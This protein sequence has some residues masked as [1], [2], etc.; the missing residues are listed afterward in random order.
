[1]FAIQAILFI[2]FLAFA[3]FNT[4]KSL[5]ITKDQRGDPKV[6]GLNGLRA[7]TGWLAFL[8][9]T[10]VVLPSFGQV[11]AGHRGVVLRFGA[12]SGIVLDEGLYWVVPFVQSVELMDVQVHADKAVATAASR[13]LQDV[14]AEVTVNYRLDFRRVSEVYRDLRHDYVIRVMVPAVQEAV[15]SATAQFDAERLIVERQTVKDRIE[16]ILTTRLAQHGIIVDGI[17]ITEFKFSDSFSKAI[18]D[19][20]T[21]TQQALKAKNDLERVQMEVGQRVA[22]ATAEAEAIRIQAQ[23]ITS[24]GGRA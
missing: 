10:F 16:T 12:V 21:A 19:K 1:M 14:G 15:K 8:F 2:L 20:V 6:T 17:S 24:Q 3:I 7:G 4:F 22:S 18:E 5:R 13:D 23:A 11:P 9:L